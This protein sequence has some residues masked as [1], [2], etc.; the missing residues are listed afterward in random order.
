[1]K[2]RTAEVRDLS[3]LLDLLQQ[4]IDDDADGG[5]ERDKALTVGEVLEMLGRRAYGPQLLVIGLVSISPAALIP[6]STWAFALLTLVVATQL[7]FHKRTPWLPRP[8]LKMKL[9]ERKLGKFIDMA[10]PS[11]RAI[12]RVVRPRLQF[13]TEPPWVIAVAAFCVVA[14]LIT[15][16]LGLIPLAPFLPGVAIALFG[17]GLTARDGLLITLGGVSIGLAMWLLLTRL[18]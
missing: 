18:V 8:A 13:I 12:D 16:P 3:S 14:A 11:S 10:R 7:A 17:L 6:G 4:K 15:F 5:A 2:R 9:S 1:M